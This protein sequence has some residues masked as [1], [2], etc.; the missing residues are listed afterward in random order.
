M[1]TTIKILKKYINNEALF[2]EKGIYK[3]VDSDIINLISCKTLSDY[4]KVKEL[5]NYISLQELT[6]SGCLLWLGNA[7][8]DITR[9]D[10]YTLRGKFK[11]RK[12]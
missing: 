5:Y 6:F 8:I 12:N 2:F 1:K 9:K 4:E 11:M 10:F 7:Y 3:K